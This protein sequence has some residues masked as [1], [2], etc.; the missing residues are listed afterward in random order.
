MME[1]KMLDQL[2]SFYPLGN[3]T[4]EGEMRLKTR[5]A[6]FWVVV[7]VGGVLFLSKLL[8]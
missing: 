3:T 6:L 2:K 4:Y 5:M 8:C 1:V 7:I